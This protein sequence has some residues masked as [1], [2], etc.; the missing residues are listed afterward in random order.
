MVISPWMAQ[1]PSASMATPLTGT[2]NGP[3]ITVNSGTFTLT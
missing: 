1:S 2:G 3:V